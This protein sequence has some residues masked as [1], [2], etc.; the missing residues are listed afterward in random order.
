[1]SM[2]EL[3][4]AAENVRVYARVSP[5]HKLKIVHALQQS[6]H[7]VSMTGDGVNDA[8][9]LARSDVGI[10][11]GAAASDV[12]LRS[13]DVAIM[14]DDMGRL[15]IAVRLAR[16]TRTTIHQNVSLGAGTSL[17]FIWLASAGI[18]A[19]LTGALLHNIGAALVLL[20]S[21][22]LLGFAAAPNKPRGAG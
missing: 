16:R 19:P 15:P 5:E 20:N 17:L 18:V 1:M 14:A 8:L 10:A 7:V 13:A 4:A 22:R 2:E 12:A 11:L 3:I 6:G 9:A 21:A